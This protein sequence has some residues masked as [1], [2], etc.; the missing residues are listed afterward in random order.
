MIFLL[1]LFQSTLPRRERL[2]HLFN[3]DP[4]Q[5][6]SIHAPAK[7]ATKGSWKMDNVD[8]ISI[9]A[10]A[11]GATAFYDS[12]P[13]GTIDFN[14]RSREGSD[15]E[16]KMLVG[17]SQKFQSTLP[18]RERQKV[19]TFKQRMFDISIHA[20][21]KGATIDLTKTNDWISISIHAPAKGATLYVKS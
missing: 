11:K 5:E 1:I 10:P 7:G 4:D 3:L 12:L 6:I 13:S 18:R 15:E 19:Y 20:P 16:Y 21:A 8:I 2:Y 17:V 9:H 14:P